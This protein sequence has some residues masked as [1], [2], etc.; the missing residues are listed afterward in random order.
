MHT[1]V[2]RIGISTGG[3]DAPGLNAVIRAVTKSAITRYG[4]E[5]MGIPDGFDGLLEPGK[6][7]P[8]DFGAVRGILPRGGTILGASNRSNP[9]NYVVTEGGGK[10][11]VQ[12][13]SDRVIKNASDLGLDVLI[14]IGGDGTLR[15]AHE[16]SQKGL[17][18]VACPKTI[19]N[20]ILHTDLTFGFDTA[21]NTAMEALDRLHTT[22]ESHHRVMILEV[23]GRD[24]GWIAL[25]SGIAG[26]ADVI[27]LPEIPFEM[28]PIVEK[29]QSRERRGARFSII[30]VAEGARLAGGETV[31]RS[32]HEPGGMKR[33]GGIGEDLAERLR[34]LIH[35]EVRVTV[36]GH[37]QRGGSP[38]AFDRWL[39]SRFGSKA[40]DLAAQG[41][42]DHMVALQGNQLT[43]VP[44]EAAAAGQ[45]FVPLDGDEIR[46]ALGLA[47]CLGQEM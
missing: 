33:L 9:F 47:I 26:G 31:Y 18:V 20:D 46:T 19:D 2:R 29:I 23:M 42:L 36:L 27:L 43:A 1:A 39:G 45:K 4:W 15:I 10:Q 44:I 8:L 24:A 3:G 7:R 12:D 40:V 25:R 14:V 32:H 28:G 17:R 34:E 6:A 35:K 38:T 21:L 22:A 11:L 30:V 37:V 41:Q 13:V 16:L 5:V